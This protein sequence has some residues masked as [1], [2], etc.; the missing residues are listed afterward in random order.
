MPGAGSE[1]EA[2]VGVVLGDDQ[3]LIAVGQP[4]LVDDPGRD[5]AG[6]GGAEQLPALP[7]GRRQRLP[8]LGVGTAGG[9]RSASCRR[10]RCDGRPARPCRPGRWPRP[11]GAVHRAYSEKVQQSGW[12]SRCPVRFRTGKGRP[13]QAIEQPWLGRPRRRPAPSRQAAPA[14]GAAN[15]GRGAPRAAGVELADDRL[16]VG[17]QGGDQALVDRQGAG[18]E[19]R[20]GR[21]RSGPGRRSPRGRSAACRRRPCSGRASAATSPRRSSRARAPAGTG[22]ACSGSPR[23]G[24]RRPGRSPACPPWGGRRGGPGS[25][26]RGWRGRGASS[27]PSTSGRPRARGPGWRSSSSR[28]T[29]SSVRSSGASAGSPGPSEPRARA[30]VLPLRPSACSIV[31]APSRIEAAARTWVSG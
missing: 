4:R 9:G 3:D 2:D 16:G 24:T 27:R 13:S 7:P 5:G 25:R 14:P 15:R 18:L 20:A 1:A 19:R 23:P 21:R 26:G 11:R 6:A 28:S 8:Q 10:R 22:S 30:T 31:R 17:L 29:T 12:T